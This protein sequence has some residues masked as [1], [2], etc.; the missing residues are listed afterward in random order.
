MGLA[1]AKN[2][3]FTWKD[4]QTWPDDERWELIGGEAIAMTPAPGTRHQGIQQELGR[5]FGNHFA[6]KKCQVF[7]APTDVKLSEEDIVQPD[8]LVVCEQDQIKPTHIEGA[9]ALIIEILSRSTEVYDRKRKLPLYASHGVK[10]VWL[11]TPY[12]WLI[13]VYVLDGQ[14]YRLHGTYSKDDTLESPS[15]PEL[16]MDLQAVFDFPI[17]PGERIKMVKEGR[18]PYVKK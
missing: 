9:P 3:H 11:V 14:T 15:F 8:L 2:K 4:Y 1:L 6:G 17:E 10:E 13:E 12:P 18:S 7:P 5:Q 16:P